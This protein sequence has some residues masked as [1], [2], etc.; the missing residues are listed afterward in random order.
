MLEMDYKLKARAEDVLTQLQ[1]VSG[2]PSIM[3]VLIR[4]ADALE[5]ISVSLE[6]LRPEAMRPKE[7]A[8]NGS[9]PTNHP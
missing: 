8:P 2:K 6:T 3:D 7:E 4:I 9:E 1:G 5:H